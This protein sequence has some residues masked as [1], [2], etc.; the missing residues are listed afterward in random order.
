MH[1][2]TTAAGSALAGRL[3]AAA[4]RRVDTLF[5]AAVV[6]GRHEAL[7]ASLLKGAASAEEEGA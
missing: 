5:D 1:A 6:A 4:G 3:G 2:G 7:Y